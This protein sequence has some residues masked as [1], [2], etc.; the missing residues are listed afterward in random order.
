MAVIRD[1]AAGDKENLVRKVLAVYRDA[2]DKLRAA[3]PDVADL[4]DNRL[5]PAPIVRNNSS[6]FGLTQRERDFHREALES[7]VR[8]FRSLT[9][10]EA[11]QGLEHG[12]VLLHD[13]RGTFV[14]MPRERDE[15]RKLVRKVTGIRPRKTGQPA[16]K[17]IREGEAS[18]QVP[19]V[20]GLL[21]HLTWEFKLVKV[22]MDPYQWRR[23]C[24]ALSFVGKG[25]D[26]DG[27]TDVAENH[28]DYLVDAIL[29]G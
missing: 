22:T 20:A 10:E 6:P 7:I 27:A 18:R 12:A 4:L 3:L 23:R 15:L 8:R 2:P 25:R 28:D 19:V 24:Q 16:E 5:S 29:N 17:V 26:K 9:I 11:I 13:N 21:L 14:P 1:L